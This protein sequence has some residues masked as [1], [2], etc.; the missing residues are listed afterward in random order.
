ML[1]TTMAIPLMMVTAGTPLPALIDDDCD[2]LG[3]D[4]DIDPK[5]SIHHS[6][7]KRG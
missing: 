6:V 5:T 7:T 3:D 1:V 4:D 2:K